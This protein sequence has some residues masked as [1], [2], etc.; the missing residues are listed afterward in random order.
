MHCIVLKEK[1]S[2]AFIRMGDRP[3]IFTTDWFSG[4]IPI[5]SELLKHFKDVPT[6]A[7]EV[8]SYQGRSGS[9]LLENILTHPDSTLT[10]V[11]TFE[12]SVEHNEE[13]K[14]G[15]YELFS[16]NMERFSSK[17][18]VHRGSSS[19]VLRAFP[20]AE[21]YDLIYIDGDHRA[22][23]V[24]E[25]A[26][27]AFPLLRKGGIMIFDDYR[28]PGGDDHWDRPTIAIDAFVTI[29]KK[30]VEVILNMYQLAIR[31]V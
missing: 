3:Y 15:I 4:N 22:E 31:K 12:G 2:N 17:L 1:R 9:W 6:T 7:L 21:T 5:W 11:D 30:S 24:I 10:C 14:K 27:L 28:F 23:T 25:D 18:R 26:I 29:Y 16:H 8:G 20:R 13:Q 19:D